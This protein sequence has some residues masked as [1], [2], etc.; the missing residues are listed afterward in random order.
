MTREDILSLYLD[1]RNNWLTV[2]RWAEYY[3]LTEKQAARVLKQ[4]KKINNDLN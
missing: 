4:G 2:S 1:Y 3:S